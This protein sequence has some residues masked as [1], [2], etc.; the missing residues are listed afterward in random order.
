MKYN[1]LQN[2]LTTMFDMTFLH[3]FS[4][5]ELENMMPWERDVYIDLIKAK[6]QEE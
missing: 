3:R 1:N 6:E 4:V 5:S 2:Y